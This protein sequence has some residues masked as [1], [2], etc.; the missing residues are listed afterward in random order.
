MLSED[1]RS[2]EIISSFLTSGGAYLLWQIVGNNFIISLQLFAF[3]ALLF[4]GIV[5][6]CEDFGLRRQSA[7]ATPLFDCGQSFQSGVALR[8][9]P[10]SKIIWLRRG[11][12][13]FFA[14]E[15]E[16]VLINEIRVNPLSVTREFPFL[17]PFSGYPALL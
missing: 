11:L 8:F 9:P 5:T 2:F 10:Q 12:A 1:G 17:H 16:F 6:S 14:V 3:F 13:V 4:V 15:N 7:T